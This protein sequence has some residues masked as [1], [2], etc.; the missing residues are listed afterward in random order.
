MKQYIGLISGT[1]VDGVDAVVVNDDIKLLAHCHLPYPQ[2]LRTQLK[3]IS[4]TLSLNLH[5]LAE[6][7]RAVAA[8]FSEA[9]VSV[10]KKA[11]LNAQDIT[12]IG[13]HGQTIYHLPKRYS[14]QIGHPALIA[15][16]TGICVVADF[17]MND[18]AAGGEGA[19]LMPAFHHF[20]LNSTPANVLNLGGIANL[21]IDDSRRLRAFDTGPA[22]TLMD[23]WIE[24]HLN[25]PYDK[26]GHWAK[27]GLLDIKLLQRLLSDAYFNK[28]PPKSTGVE[29]FNLNWLNAQLNGN[30]KPQDVQRT[31]L[32]LSAQSIANCIDNTNDIFICGGG[33]H[34]DFL[35]QRIRELCPHNTVASTAVLS[36]HPD[37]VEAAGFAYLAKKTLLKEPVINITHTNGARILGGIYY[38]S[39]HSQ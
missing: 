4:Q 35:I 38:A 22:N 31:L 29:Y 18:I 10:L 21:T 39:K 20:F 36:I 37:Y 32:E 15:E 12:A 8:L 9:A 2:K 17:R 3:Q 7:D 1:S 6:I 30:E 14:L 25:K 27:D 33:V 16:Q 26:Q 19:P 34:N 11:A 5:T 13:S 24:T 28:K 23:N